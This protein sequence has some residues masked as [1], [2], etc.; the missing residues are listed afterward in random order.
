MKRLEKKLNVNDF[1]PEN[2]LSSKEMKGIVGGWVRVLTSLPHLCQT[3][4]N[5]AGHGNI[6]ECE[7]G[8]CYDYGPYAS[9]RNGSNVIFTISC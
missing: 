8:T 9:C 6:R 3:A 1:D 5:G 7:E 4:C 2:I